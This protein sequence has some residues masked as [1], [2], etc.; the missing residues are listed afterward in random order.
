METQIADNLYLG[1][2][3]DAEKW[4]TNKLGRVICVMTQEPTPRVPE[5]IWIPIM[6]IDCGSHAIDDT[7]CRDNTK[8]LEAVS[9]TISMLLASGELVLVHC[10]LGRDRSPLA[11]AWYLHRENKTSLVDAYA[12]VK[13]KRPIICPHMDWVPSIE[14]DGRVHLVDDKSCHEGWCGGAYNYPKSC[15]RQGCD[16]LVHAEFGDEDSDCNY[17]LYTKCDKCGEP[18]AK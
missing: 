16:G 14:V 15:G 11:I 9:N 13:A 6:D 1:D 5:R 2:Y 18:E 3:N 7:K 10:A 4:L 12:A 8:S 17:W